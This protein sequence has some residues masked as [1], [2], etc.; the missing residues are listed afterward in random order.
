MKAFDIVGVQPKMCDYCPKNATRV[1]ISREPTTE[2]AYACDAA[3]CIAFAGFISGKEV[4]RK[5]Y[6]EIRKN[7]RFVPITTSPVGDEDDEP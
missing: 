4:A 7:N 6:E 5:E 3:E 1:V 2:M